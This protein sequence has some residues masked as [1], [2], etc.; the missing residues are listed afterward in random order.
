MQ[1]EALQTKLIKLKGYTISRINISHHHHQHN[2]LITCIFTEQ[3]V[4]I[5]VA[6]RSRRGQLVKRSLITQRDWWSAI[7]P[8]MHSHA[9]GTGTDV[10]ICHH[11]HGNRACAARP[12]TLSPAHAHCVLDNKGFGDPPTAEVF[13]LPTQ[14]KHRLV[15][16]DVAEANASRNDRCNLRS[17]SH[18]ILHRVQWFSQ[19]VDKKAVCA[20]MKV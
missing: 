9:A 13:G 20:V 10:T 3:E 14:V 15:F 8:P 2:T 19:T 16:D 17:L 5:T 18:W 4:V 12:A 6:E 11:R 1:S 7:S